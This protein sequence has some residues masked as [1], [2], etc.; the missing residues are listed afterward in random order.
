MPL[1]RCVWQMRLCRPPIKA[2]VA[3]AA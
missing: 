3:L 2:P 1:R